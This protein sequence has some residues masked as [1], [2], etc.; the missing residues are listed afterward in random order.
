MEVQED[1]N[2]PLV[3][4]DQAWGQGAHSPDTLSAAEHTSAA[5]LVLRVRR[6]TQILVAAILVL[7]I[8]LSVSIATRDS[9]SFMALGLGLVLLLVAVRLART[10]K[11]RQG[12]SLMLITLTLLVFYLIYSANGVSDVAVLAFPAILIFASMIGTRRLFFLL[13]SLIAIGLC[14]I[15]AAHEFGWHVNSPANPSWSVLVNALG[16]IGATAFFIA[17]MSDDLNQALVRLAAEN[18][19]LR[20]S[21]AQIEIIASHDTLTSLPNRALASDRLS[22]IVAASERNDAMAAVMLIDLDNFKT[23]NDSL[24]HGA[25]D[26]LL[27]EVADRLSLLTG[28]GDTVS[29]PGGDEFLLLF[30]HLDDEESAVSAAKQVLAR[31]ALPFHTGG[32]EVHV[33]ASLGI[34]MCPRDGQD[35]DTLFKNADMAMHRAK[36]AGR[37][38]YCFFNPEMN[39]SVIDHLHLV[40]GIKA[41]LANREFE[42]YYQPQFDLKSGRISGA[43]ALL[44]WRHPTLGFIPPAKFIPVAERSGLINEIGAW[45][46]DGACAQAKAWQ[47]AG[48]KGLVMSINVSPVQF[49]RDDIEREVVNALVKWQLAP[50]SIELELTESLLIADAKHLGGVLSRLRAM[51]VKFSID[52]FGTGYSNLGYLKRFEVERLKIDQSFV[53]RMADNADDEGI[54]RA[55]VE[56]AHCL[57]LEVVAEGVENQLTLDRLIGFGCEFGQGY[58]WAQAMPAAEFESY[59][60]VTRSCAS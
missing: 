42:I 59:F 18:S 33:S 21:H 52:D 23:I 5:G 15:V 45:V 40:S 17:M 24:G 58:H 12:A 7:T 53:R 56:M 19:R 38:T 26:V 25:G 22:Q 4:A 32:M 44:R 13:L 28:D 11:V 51:G 3:S 39:E 9:A 55:I 48:M 49:R 27:C 57:K 16:I 43:E 20:Q 30:A 60:H 41:A 14:A 2:A 47:D 34:A 1:V 10:R 31:L 46:L 37:N 35:S 54:V 29:R 36:D 6:M 8:A 50:E